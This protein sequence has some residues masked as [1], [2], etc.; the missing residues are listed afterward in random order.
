MTGPDV[1]RA[2]EERIEERLYETKRRRRRAYDHR[3]ADVNREIGRLIAAAAL[4][5]LAAVMLRSGTLSGK[6]VEEALLRDEGVGEAVRVA[7]RTAEN[8][9]EIW[10][11]LS[12]R[13][14][15]EDSAVSA[16]RTGQAARPGTAERGGRLDLRD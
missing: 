5:V 7:T 12:G 3:E 2:K 11:T 13:E 6:D 1:M 14:D 10:E 9:A 16:V 15:G 8:L 4:T